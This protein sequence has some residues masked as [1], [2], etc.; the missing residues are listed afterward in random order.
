MCCFVGSS[1]ATFIFCAS[2]G[3]SPREAL[4]HVM[5]HLGDLVASSRQSTQCTRS[6]NLNMVLLTPSHGQRTSVAESQVRRGGRAA[7]ARAGGCL[8]GSDSESLGIRRATGQTRKF[9]LE[10]AT[11]KVGTPPS[12]GCRTGRGRFGGGAGLRRGGG[13]RFAAAVQVAA[14]KMGREV[15]S[16][17]PGHWAPVGPGCE[18]EWL[19]HS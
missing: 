14:P 3:A 2:A 13:Q 7:A 12:R 18:G 11:R 8:G 4:Q 9:G 16:E 17:S 15:K 5:E 6:A 10:R 1:V 19:V